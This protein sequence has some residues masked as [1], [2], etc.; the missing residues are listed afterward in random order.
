MSFDYLDQRS[1]VKFGMTCRQAQGFV[2]SYFLRRIG[3]MVKHFE[4]D[5]IQLLESMS[6][7]DAVISGDYASLAFQPAILS[8][9]I[10]PLEL[11]FNVHRNSARDFVNRLMDL[12]EFGLV[13]DTIF[14][15]EDGSRYKR[16]WHIGHRASSK[17]LHKDIYIISFADDSLHPSPPAFVPF[18]VFPLLL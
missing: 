1:V 12:G 17:L 11:V 9:D 5:P 13:S 16:K 6:S 2:M 14:Y 3:E 7:Y 10:A 4:L 18:T 8:R 15:A